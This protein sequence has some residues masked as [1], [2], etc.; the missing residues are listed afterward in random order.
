MENKEIIANMIIANLKRIMKI[1]IITIITKILINKITNNLNK[2]TDN[3][4]IKI[5]INNR[6]INHNIKNQTTK[7][8]QDR[9]MNRLIN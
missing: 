4:I 5:S 7:L 8:L 2:I 9:T 3:I 6:T 1:E